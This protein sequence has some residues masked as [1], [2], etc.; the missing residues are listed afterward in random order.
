MTALDHSGVSRMLDVR[1]T[2]IC[3][4]HTCHFHCHSRTELLEHF[5][6]EHV[7]KKSLLQ[8]VTAT[9]A[10]IEGSISNL[11]TDSLRTKLGVTKL[12]PP[13]TISLDLESEDM[14]P[15]TIPNQVPD[16]CE[17]AVD[18]NN[19][20]ILSIPPPPD[21][22]EPGS[23]EDTAFNECMDWLFLEWSIKSWDDDRSKSLMGSVRADNEDGFE[24]WISCN[25]RL[26]YHYDHYVTARENVFLPCTIRGV[27]LMKDGQKVSLVVP[28]VMRPMKPK[29][30]KSN[31]G[32]KLHR[33][34]AEVTLESHNDDMIGEDCFTFRCTKFRSYQGTGKMA[35]SPAVM[36][37]GVP[38]RLMVYPDG[39][40]AQD[41]GEYTSVFLEVDKTH[42]TT[43][44]WQCFVHFKLD[45]LSSKARHT[46]EKKAAHR[47]TS[48]SMNW[49]FGQL[50]SL[51][52]VLDADK[53][54][55]AADGSV[56][57]RATVR[58]VEGTDIEQWGGHTTCVRFGTRAVPCRAVL[59]CAC[60]V[61]CCVVV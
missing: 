40:S 60:C 50:M 18:K 11:S 7:T 9:T 27:R 30:V 35:R 43:A 25:H 4:V 44:C 52:E 56:T 31:A 29:H 19:V 21:G 20:I 2:Y 57:F 37:G 38:W 47:F 10:A 49:G 22:V 42:D 8:S 24:R 3:P 17:L 45:I 6:T 15:T 16:P 58:V 39:N 51:A 53:G 61:L 59:R 12:P 34:H 13:D 46:Y 36:I 55:L 28:E 48:T 54:Y 23:A 14:D 32:W 5:R 41:Q 33:E 1:P 26:I